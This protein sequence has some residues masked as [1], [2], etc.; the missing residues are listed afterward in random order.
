MAQDSDCKVSDAGAARKIISSFRARLNETVKQ[1]LERGQ[2]RPS[3]AQNLV[4]PTT[5]VTMLR[6]HGSVSRAG[7]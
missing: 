7:R 1:I 6:R 5:S 4:A 3:D 2:G